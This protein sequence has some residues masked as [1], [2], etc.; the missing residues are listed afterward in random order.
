MGDDTSMSDHFSHFFAVADVG[1]S[2]KIKDLAHCIIRNKIHCN[3]C[4]DFSLRPVPSVILN[5]I[6]G[7]GKHIWG[8]IVLNLYLPRRAVEMTD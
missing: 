6:L 7:I 2:P 3:I 5:Q 4:N 8:K 1:T